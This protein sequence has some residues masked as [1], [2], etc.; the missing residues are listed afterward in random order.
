MKPPLRASP[1]QSRATQV[2]EYFLELAR[3]GQWGERL[4]PERLL[5]AQTGVSRDTV[6]AALAILQEKGVVTERRRAG[7]R[8]RKAASAGRT[9]PYT[10]GILVAMRMDYAS[11][12][13]ISWV[14][15]L[16]RLLYQKNVVAETYDGYAHKPNFF[17]TIS[18]RTR[19]DAW[20]VFYPPPEALKWS[21]RSGVRAIMASTVDP[22]LGLPSVDIHY[23]AV[24]HHAAGRLAALGHRRLA[25]IL[26]RREWG[27]D[28]ESAAGFLEGAAAHPEV[29]ANIYHHNGTPEG[30]CELTDR[31]LAMKQ[32]PTGWITAVAP[33]SLTILMHLQR[34]GVAVPGE[35]SLIAQD[36]EPWQHFA[37]PEPTRYEADISQLARATAREIFRA[38]SG[39]TT[40]PKPQRIIPNL[41]FGRTLGPAP[42]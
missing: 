31:L 16:R 41:L 39:S 12:R 8:I 18:T 25:L 37:I 40:P 7:T 11:Y 24:C 28:K 32:R 1:Y 5:A 21:L 2:A 6:R 3:T 27:A 33:H 42:H 36:A 14:D 9:G 17:R 30:I 19:H 15:G 23:R 22:T 34:R 10:V 35:I 13:T 38:L 20:V 26:H 29:T 4:P